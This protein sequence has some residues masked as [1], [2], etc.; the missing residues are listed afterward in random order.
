M[1]KFFA[2]VKRN[3]LE[4]LRD[5]LAAVFC[6][7]FPI[8]MLVF[9]QVLVKS[10]EFAPENFMIK[11]YAAGIGVFGYTFTAMFLAMRLAG[12]KNTAFIKRVKVLPIK[13]TAY[14]FSFFAAAVPIAIVQ[15]ILFFVIALFF[16]LPF[17]G[18]WFLSIAYLM[19][20]AVHYLSFGVLVGT[21]V[22]REEK[23]GPL[24]SIAVSLTGMLGGIF[25]PVSIFTG[26]MKTIINILPFAHSTF[27]ASEIYTVGAGS[28]YPHA[29]WLV[30]YTVLYWIIVCAV[31][32]ARE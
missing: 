3:T 24:C 16:G 11:N 14:V 1:K 27:I 18:N 7:L 6:V 15:T 31:E 19:F 20:S 10:I 2:L 32:K 12:D 26:A 13:K 4:T 21:M 8:V 5:P 25:M 22:N 30:G 29:L 23:A 17:D 28:I 9:M